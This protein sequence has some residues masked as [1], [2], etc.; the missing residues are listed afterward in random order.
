MDTPAQSSVPPSGQASIYSIE[1]P[2]TNTIDNSE[3]AVGDDS[4][5]TM[6][7]R[8]HGWKVSRTPEI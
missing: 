4:H 8:V 3:K 7:P 1:R 6:P 5:A 2:L